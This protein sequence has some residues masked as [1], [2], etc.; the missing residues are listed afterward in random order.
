[1]GTNKIHL[2]TSSIVGNI[3]ELYDF[4]IYSIFIVEIGRSFFPAYSQISQILLSTLIFSIGFIARPIG[5]II[6]GHLGDKYGRKFAL[7]TSIVL[8]ASAT[9]L[10]GVLPDYSVIGLYS[11][12]GLII[13]RFMQGISFAG[14][15]IGAAIFVLESIK[16]KRSGFIAALIGSTH[17]IGML[18][19]ITVS[20]LINS[21]FMFENRWRI[22][23][24]FGGL[25]GAVGLYLR[26]YTIETA[27]FQQVLKNGQL[28]KFP[29]K[30]V[31]VKSWREVLCLICFGGLCAASVNMIISYLNIY[32]IS[33]GVPSG[34][35]LKYVLFAA[36]VFMLLMPLFGLLADC[37]PCK[38]VIKITST[39][40]L[41]GVIPAFM[42]LRYAQSVSNVV[43]LYCSLALFAFFAASI[44]GPA[45][46]Y[47]MTL[48]PTQER[49][50]GMAFSHNVGAALFAGTLPTI[51]VLL[52][53]YNILNAPAFYLAF[54]AFLVIVT[55]SLPRANNEK[56][57]Y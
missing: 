55:T 12:V 23:F 13:L 43:M 18:F 48:F 27:Q 7:S 41:L 56:V 5:G 53:T 14:E 49:Y 40:L 21:Y 46:K 4:T 17:I 22:A 6:F 26:I 44:N 8:M 9:F 39:I 3:L 25:L 1:M 36:I 28:S 31:L 16:S 54:I 11:S 51:S 42:L 2:I 34:D 37:I 32:F 30:E 52:Q 38:T 57:F 33:N 10:I 45:L 20:I 50:T 15:G 35:A 29:L 47:M 24:I 19:A